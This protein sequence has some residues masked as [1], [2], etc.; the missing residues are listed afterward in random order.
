VPDLR[1]KILVVDDNE[2]NRALVEETLRE[3]GHDLTLAKSGEE[4]LLSFERDPADLVLLD[5]RMPGLD[6]FATCARLR[7]LPGGPETPVIFLT[8][9][10]DLETYDRA[11][12]AGADDFL[13]KPI[14]P[15]E[16]LVR[17]QTLLRIRRLSVELHDH[18]RVIRRQRDDL[19]RLQLQKEQLMDFVVHDL[20]NPVNTI[21]LHATALMRRRDLTD[22]ARASAEAI[23]AEARNLTRLTHNLLDISRGAEGELSPKLAP[24]DLRALIEDVAEAMRARAAGEGQRV[25]VTVNGDPPEI[26]SDED[27]LRRVLENLLDNAIRYSPQGGAITLEMVSTTP[28]EVSVRVID[29]GPGIPEPLREKIFEKYVQIEQGPASRGGRGLGLVFCRMAI[30][31]HGGEIGVDA[32]AQG[33]VF[34]FRLRHGS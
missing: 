31:A 6:G 9:L 15:A 3:E 8:A 23:Q 10:R 4:A 5:V 22:D 26:P 32:S 12:R 7:K 16:L 13:T 27:L 2:Q 20:K 17:V 14:R 24:V 28:G 21:A 33:T 18:F 34:F 29:T 19:V 1:S 11:L 30:E 25:E